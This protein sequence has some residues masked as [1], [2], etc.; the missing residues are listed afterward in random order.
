MGATKKQPDALDIIKAM[1]VDV[2]DHCTSR[3]HRVLARCNSIV[4]NHNSI[5][6]VRQEE[7]SFRWHP[8]NYKARL[9]VNRATQI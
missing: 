9:L 8:L 5:A 6:V 4:E 7:E 3:L 2:S 1:S